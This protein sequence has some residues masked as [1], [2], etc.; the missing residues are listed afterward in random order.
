GQDRDDALAVLEQLG[1][2]PEERRAKAITPIEKDFMDAIE[3]LYGEGTKYDRDLAYSEFMQGL[4]AKY[5]DHHEVAAFY[6]ISLLGASRNGRDPELYDHSARIAQGIIKE[7]PSHPG[8]LH[9]LIHSYDDPEH[10]HLANKAADSYS[11]V[12]PDAT[13]A[14]HM[15]SHIYVALGDWDKVVTSNI[16]SWNASVRKSKERE[17]PD[18]P[19]SYHALNWLQYGLLQRG[20]TKRAAELLEN[21]IEFMNNN[22]NKNARSYLVAMKGGQLVETNDWNGKFSKFS[23]K[24]DDLNIVTRT[25]YALTE[26]LIAYHQNDIKSLARIIETISEDRSKSELLVGDKGFAMCSA[27]GYANKPPSLLDINMTRVMELELMALHADLSGNPALA[28]EHFK[29]ATDL[30]EQ[31][32][33]SYGPPDIVKPIHE[34][35]GEWLLKEGQLEAASNMFEKSLKRNPR[36]LLSYEGLRNAADQLKN[37]KLLA[38]VEDEL[39]HSTK[40]IEWDEIL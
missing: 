36:R 21:M 29:K 5:P 17:N 6:A 28:D 2:T 30:D 20:E 40:S 18:N 7:N 11:K 25:G 23:I 10:A 27:G 16:A 3:I 19:G 38:S 12:A 13:H 4:T 34:A 15:P 33:Y 8:A 1:A 35:Y 37:N 31:L 26:G 32:S 14:L 24:V 9:Y 39:Q 22:P